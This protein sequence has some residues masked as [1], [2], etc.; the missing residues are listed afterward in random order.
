MI[1]LLKVAVICLGL[2]V[3]ALCSQDK[4]LLRAQGEKNPRKLALLVGI[5]NYGR[6]RDSTMDWANLNGARDVMLL[7]KTLE[8]RLGFKKEDV[9][10]LS[11]AKATRKGIIDA[12]QNHLIAQAK[13][14]DIVVFHFSGHG[15]LMK[16]ETGRKLTGKD[17]CFVPYDYGEQGIKTVENNPRLRAYEINSLLTR[18]CDKMRENGKVKG[19]IFV[20]LDTCHSGTG[21]RGIM[22]ERGR[23]WDEKY[24]GPEPKESSSRGVGEKVTA[25]PEYVFIA[26]CKSYQSAKEDPDTK[27]GILTEHL[28]K[29]IEQS[30]PDSTYR[31]LFEKMESEVGAL[32]IAQDVQAEG[33]LDKVIFNGTVR[34]VIPYILVKP[35][36]EPDTVE[37]PAGY[38]QG[39]TGESVYSLYKAGSPV[40][41]ESNK[42]AE[43]VVTSV[44]ADTSKARI[45]KKI[46]MID[47]DALTLARAVE[48]VHNYQSSLKVL[49]ES[50]SPE[51]LKRLKILNVTNAARDNYDVKIYKKN[52][53]VVLERMD[54]SSVA[55]FKLTSA[56]DELDD[57]ISRALLEEWRKRFLM[58]MRG[59][60]LNVAIR[61]IKVDL[62]VKDR[63]EKGDPQVIAGERGNEIK[64]REGVAI[65]FEVRNNSK[66]R[67]F[68]NIIYINPEEELTALFPDPGRAAD[69][70]DITQNDRDSVPPDGK[71]H[72]IPI[73]VDRK[74]Q[75]DYT[76]NAKITK[77]R[78]FIKLIATPARI[79]LSPLFSRSD[80]GKRGLMDESPNPFDPF[81][82]LLVNTGARARAVR[83]ADSNAKGNVYG[84]AELYFEV[85]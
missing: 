33:N 44:E 1:H 85:K 4:E 31:D 70:A 11:D 75:S 43:L 84:T 73:N 51:T 3:I 19:D 20:V 41:K 68:I 69:F 5:S 10:L 47:N 23:G 9:L 54:G 80:G 21:T 45:T 30:R 59:D 22:K 8:E 14:G 40:D 60:A 49:A 38:L 7:Q 24:D 66:E 50:L 18:L 29:A 56:T 32:N 63:I 13:P 6:G 79:D 2:L 42:L 17:E 83:T 67:V 62:D 37:F 35:L 46:G 76:W 48:V 74:H 55:E 71:W 65:S 27:M 12:F 57:H 34:P 72:R 58:N 36:D 82:L 39:I 15:Q 25:N 78:D 16:D 81:S 61:L 77:G 64:L 53:K 28:I 52:D 26:A